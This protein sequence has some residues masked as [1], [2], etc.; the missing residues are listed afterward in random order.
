[1]SLPPTPQHAVADQYYA[2]ARAA[3][4]P[5]WDVPCAESL[6]A[7]LMLGYYT[8]G[9]AASG[10]MLRAK[11]HIALGGGGGRTGGR[12]QQRHR[13]THL[14]PPPSSERDGRRPGGLGG[15]CTAPRAGGHL[16]E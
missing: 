16:R 11:L 7:L 12:R 5:V 3:A 2:L 8:L 14:P 1:M 13:G 9:T 10:D 15:G 4:A 6:S